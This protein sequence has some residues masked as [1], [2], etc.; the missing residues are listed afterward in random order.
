MLLTDRR[1][2]T[3]LAERLSPE[4]VLSLLNDYLEVMVDVCLR[5]R[6]TINEIGILTYFEGLR[7]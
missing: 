1:G 2:F 3:S 4:S 5:Y 6:G 7:A